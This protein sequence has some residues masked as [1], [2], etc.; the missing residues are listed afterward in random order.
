MKIYDSCDCVRVII[1]VLLITVFLS[2]MLVVNAS[3]TVTFG[4]K[5]YVVKNGDRECGVIVEITIETDDTWTLYETNK[6]TL[7][8][9]MTP[10][11]NNVT[12]IHV[13]VSIYVGVEKWEEGKWKTI[14]NTLI[15][16]D[17]K[18]KELFIKKEVE[19]KPWESTARKAWFCVRIS[20]PGIDI[21][22]EDG[23]SVTGVDFSTPHGE[24]GPI[25]IK[26]P[27]YY[28]FMVFFSFLYL[29]RFFIPVII[30]VVIIAFYFKKKKR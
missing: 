27:T 2:S 3:G 29:I 21:K 22:Y 6:F 24:L 11:W 5:T 1:S 15:D 28:I 20:Y 16:L 8:L 26:L 13:Y 30:V 23:S 12:E 17:E 18:G 19:A 9:N 14:W 4:P 7:T 10:Y 25:E